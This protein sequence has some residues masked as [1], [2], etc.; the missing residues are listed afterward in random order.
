MEDKVSALIQCA[1]MSRRPF[2]LV[3]LACLIKCSGVDDCLDECSL[4]FIQRSCSEQVNQ[5]S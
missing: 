3:T 2:V 1:S 5:E 4:Y